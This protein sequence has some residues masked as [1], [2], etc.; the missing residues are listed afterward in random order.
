VRADGTF[1]L[2]PWLSHA[3]PEARGA[4]VVADHRPAWPWLVL[5]A[6]HPLMIAALCFSTFQMALTGRREWVRYSW[7]VYFVVGVAMTLVAGGELIRRGELREGGCV[8][9]F[10]LPFVTI[11]VGIALIQR[12][13]VHV[14]L[15]YCTAGMAA[16]L[17]QDCVYRFDVGAFLATVLPSQYFGVAII[18]VG[19]LL[20][21]SAVFWW[22]FRLLKHDEE[23]YNLVWAGVLDSGDELRGLLAVRQEAAALT[24]HCNSLA[25]PRQLNRIPRSVNSALRRSRW[26]WPA[27]LRFLGVDRKGQ[28]AGER[29]DVDVDWDLWETGIEGTVDPCLPLDSMD[30]L[31]LQAG[32]LQPLLI[33]K[34]Q[35]WALQSGGFFRCVARLLLNGPLTQ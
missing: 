22:A 9:L 34:T 10:S 31:F 29:T 20:S 14:F 30:Q 35:A 4:V 2:Y 15:A 13:L 3:V 16:H 19:I 32:C 17:V 7:L 6:G 26:C 27:L 8:L 23:R 5:W 1:G 12:L 21:R 11:G 33:H 28:A 24:R 25:V 18:F